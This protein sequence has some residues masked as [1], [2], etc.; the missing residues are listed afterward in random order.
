VITTDKNGREIMPGDTLK[1]F[2]FIGARRKKYF[3]YKYVESLSYS[4]F[5]IAHL[6]L[7]GEKYRMFCDGKQHD[8]I[9]IVQGYGA[10]NIFFDE[11]ERVTR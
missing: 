5:T 10:N 4:L 1:I 3:M 11:R 2:H 6:N 8:D 9:E 7:G